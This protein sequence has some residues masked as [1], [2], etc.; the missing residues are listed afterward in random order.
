MVEPADKVR[1]LVRPGGG[2]PRVE[3]L[4]NSMRLVRLSSFALL[5]SSGER[6]PGITSICCGGYGSF[7]TAGF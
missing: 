6:R 7:N 2:E 3:R 4:L 5:L 1:G